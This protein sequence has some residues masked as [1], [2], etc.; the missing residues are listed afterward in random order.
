M[1]KIRCPNCGTT[2][3]LENRRKID[4]SLI[5]NAL[6]KNPKT[7][8]DLLHLT[9]LPRKTLSMRLKDLCN[10]KVIDKYEYGRYRLNGDSG[11]AASKVGISGFRW[12]YGDG[13]RLIRSISLVFI[14]GM[15][16]VSLASALISTLH[17]STPLP[18]IA[19]FIISPDPPCYAGW[20]EE[21]L[22][23]DASLSYDPDGCIIGYHWKFGDGSCGVG[24][25]VTHGYTVPGRYAVEL[26]V[27]DDRGMNSIARSSLTVLPTPCMK[28]YVD[29]PHVTGLTVGDVFTVN[30][31]ISDVTNLAAW[32]AGM[33]FDPNVLE[34]V[35][36][37]VL[38]PDENGNWVVPRISAFMEGPFLKQGGETLFVPPEN[39]Y[40]G[41]GAIQ[42]H[43]CCIFTT[44][45]PVSGS[46]TLASIT[47]KVI[48]PGTSTLHL[49]HLTLLNYNELEI[50]VLSVEDG[51]FQLP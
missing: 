19:S 34:C 9:G 41:E 50:P 11:S 6:R 44:S 48:A 18:P 30:I 51:Y 15:L 13:K 28:V 43:G 29:S 46:G 22:S 26:K 5:L 1:P 16:L 39:I 12:R 42:S 23:F 4:F 24:P 17:E 14:V 35:T 8:T 32:Q 21:T 25:V 27:T 10:S 38:M 37:E 45:I 20:G 31:V 33:T 47:F 36:T 40:N 7:F 2:I 3:D 49:T